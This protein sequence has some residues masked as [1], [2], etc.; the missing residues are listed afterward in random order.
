MMGKTHLA[1]ALAAWSYMLPATLQPMNEQE[2]IV[3]GVGLGL[4][5]IGGILPDI[6]QPG[7]TI[8]QELFGPLGKTRIGAML[9]GLLLLVI[10]FVLRTPNVLGRV[11]DSAV[12]LNLIQRHSFWVSLI[13]GI[14]GATLVI[15]ASLKHRGITHTL[16]GMGVFMW[17]LDTL[18]GLKGLSFLLPWRISLLVVFGAGYFS[19]LLLDL[20]SDGVP[21]LYP[22]IKKRIRLPISISTNS[23]LDK[24][25]CRYCLLS[26][27]TYRIVG[28]VWDKVSPS[29]MP[30]Y[31]YLR[32]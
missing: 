24:V 28:P 17:G 4:A 18:L 32:G 31:H 29:L 23:L 5:L 21:L 2:T 12:L 3:M 8:D 15:I 6:D 14:L 30:V 26:F 9:G 22:L 13:V 19:H 1:G 10:S 7:S 20:I 16:L 27:A 25:V 11:L